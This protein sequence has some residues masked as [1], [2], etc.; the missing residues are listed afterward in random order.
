MGGR[1]LISQNA[2]TP[3]WSAA[4]RELFF[5]KGEEL[6]A[7]RY[8][9]RSEEFEMEPPRPLFKAPTLGT[10]FDVSEDGRR[11]LFFLPGEGRSA[12]QEVHV[13]LSGFEELK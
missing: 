11:F 7:A 5:I 1:T 12:R 3:R 9:S 8:G 6:M 10:S 13:R 2:H 4:S